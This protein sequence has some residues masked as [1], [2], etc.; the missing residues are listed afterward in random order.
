[1]LLVLLYLGGGDNQQ[2]YSGGKR[3]ICFH[4]DWELKGV[5]AGCHPIC[6]GAASTHVT[7]EST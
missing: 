3:S 1:M 5:P 6:H 4:N 7:R 2:L